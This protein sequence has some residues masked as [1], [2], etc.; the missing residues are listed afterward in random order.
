MHGFM[1]AGAGINASGV[2][3]GK[4]FDDSFT[5]YRA[6][7]KDGMGAQYIPLLGGANNAA[8]GLND[9]GVIV[10]YSDTGAGTQVAFR[11]SSAGG[12][13]SLGTP[14]GA[15]S[16]WANAVNSA[17][18]IAAAAG[19]SSS[20][21]P[22]AFLNGGW[23]VLQMPSGYLSGEATAISDGGLIVGTLSRG[24]ETTAF[25]W[26]G[27]QVKPLTGLAKAYGV[28]SAGLV[29]GTSGTSALLY[30]DSAVF[31]LNTLLG[32][33]A[34]TWDLQQAV[35]INDAG[36]I[37]GT[38]VHDGVQRAF[39]LTPSGEAVPEP[40][41]TATFSGGLLCLA[42]FWRLKCRIFRAVRS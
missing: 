28:N 8:T 19:D 36:W 10:G 24:D 27:D 14:V 23:L 21:S 18:G 38:G 22:A 25:L 17:G 13:E 39:L 26:D 40:A 5:V 42:A 1:A 12:V 35:A 37:V 20:T 29:V 2:V 6:F 32:P 9:S 31:D 3:V 7:V 33:A 15:A 30:R 41:T 16:T 4:E 34:S 11:Y